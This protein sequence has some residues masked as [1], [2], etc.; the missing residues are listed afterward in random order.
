MRPGSGQ[1]RPGSAQSGGRRSRTS[2]RQEAEAAAAGGQPV[3]D[4]YPRRFRDEAAIDFDEQESRGSGAAGG[5]GSRGLR[6]YQG[7]YD[8]DDDHLYDELGDVGTEDEDGGPPP[9]EPIFPLRYGDE[10]RYL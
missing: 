10:G 9:T 6:E 5:G 3:K 1:G 7:E 4:H 2:S 8:D